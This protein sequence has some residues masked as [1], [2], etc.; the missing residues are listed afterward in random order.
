M[1]LT[2]DLSES[3]ALFVEAEIKAGRFASASEVV[4]EALLLLRDVQRTPQAFEGEDL[5][6][7]R[8]AYDEGVASGDAGEI[9]FE[10]LKREG[11]RRLAART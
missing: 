7:L 6:F 3:E 2:I 1:N 10:E 4:R 9:D 8:R 11:R 5:A